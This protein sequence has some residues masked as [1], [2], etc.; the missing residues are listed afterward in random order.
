MQASGAQARP[1]SGFWGTSSPRKAL[2]S[3]YKAFVQP[4]EEMGGVTGHDRDQDVLRA[5]VLQIIHLLC[6]ALRDQR[7]GTKPR[8]VQKACELAG[9]EQTQLVS[10]HA[11]VQLREVIRSARC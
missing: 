7:S 10:R 3:V 4:A 6:C 8:Q 2:A 9:L 1:S 11:S 5:P